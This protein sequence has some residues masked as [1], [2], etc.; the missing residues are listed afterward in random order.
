MKHVK[1]ITQVDAYIRM[2]VR[3]RGGKP[4][5]PNQ[6]LLDLQ[7]QLLMEAKAGVAAQW[8]TARHLMGMERTMRVL[9]GNGVEVLGAGK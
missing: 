1:E 5:N 3:A 7:T 2:K 9:G 4:Q 8:D 6:P